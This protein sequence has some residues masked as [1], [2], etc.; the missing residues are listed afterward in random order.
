VIAR[1]GSLPRQGGEAM[2][3]ALAEALIKWAK[4]NPEP[5]PHMHWL[6]RHR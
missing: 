3:H 1:K 5:Y 6:P 2:H 4:Q